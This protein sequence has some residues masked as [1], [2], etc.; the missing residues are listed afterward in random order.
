MGAHDDRDRSPEKL[1]A[2]VP[3]GTWELLAPTAGLGALVFSE[4]HLFVRDPS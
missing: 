4:A 3:S 2:A 1:K